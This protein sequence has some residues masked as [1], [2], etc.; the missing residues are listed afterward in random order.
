VVDLVPELVMAIGG[1][2]K[3]LVAAEVM[4]LAGQGLVEHGLL[5]DTLRQG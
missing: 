3:A 5:L 2:T 4:R 1:I